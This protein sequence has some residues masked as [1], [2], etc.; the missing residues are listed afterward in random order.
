VL[1]RN[2]KFRL[3]P[4]RAQQAALAQT[5]ELCRQVY[6]TALE[7][8][9][10]AWRRCRKSLTFF[11]QAK[12][13]S[14]LKK[15]CPEFKSVYSQVLLSPLDRLDKSFKNFF[16]RVKAHQTPGFPRFK[17]RDRFDSFAYTQ[18]GFSLDEQ[19][20]RVSLSKIGNLK[21][22]QWRT[23]PGKP[24]RVT[25]KRE[26]DGWY[27]IFCCESAPVLLS[28]TG[29]ETGFDVGLTSLVTDSSGAEYGSLQELKTAELALRKSQ[30]AFARKK[31]GSV[32]R[33]R[34]RTLLAKKHQ[35]FARRRAHA[36][37]Q[38]S[39]DIIR[40][41]DLIALE[42]LDIRQMVR[43]PEQAKKGLTKKQRTGLR[44]NIHQA[45][46]GQLRA[47]IS[48][49]AEEAGRKVVLV[50]PR[51]TTQNCSTCDTVV[52]K[53]LRDRMHNC[54]ACGL[55][56]G[57]DHN[58]A[59]NILKRALRARRGGLGSKAEPVKRKVH[60]KKSDTFARASTS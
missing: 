31:K 38:I 50:D 54:P 49:K 12:E 17:G 9:I 2:Y 44:R 25:I 55:V 53:T 26:A 56:L 20:S 14:P 32:R 24:K 19:S 46:W 48:Y 52:P 16:R 40:E 4:T 13:L 47:Q 29:K 5:L 7:Q 57:R 23:L 27:A 15:S 30:R 59:I 33:Q 34:Q 10:S 21:I 51:G 37:H 11:D 43:K 1:L 36:L 58:A 41:N 28:S 8:R 60:L 35:Q 22:K 45:A 18:N 39:R 42:A 6:N 3:Y